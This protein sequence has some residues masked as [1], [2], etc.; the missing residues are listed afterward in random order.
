MYKEHEQKLK[1][2]NVLIT[3]NLCTFACF[4]HIIEKFNNTCTG[5]YEKRGPSNYCCCF[6]K[7]LFYQLYVKKNLN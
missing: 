2:Y 5:N 3:C 1:L 4:S 6:F 7:R